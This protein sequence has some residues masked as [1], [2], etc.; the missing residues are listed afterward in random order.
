VVNRNDQER[1]V[2]IEHPVRNDFK[3]IDTDKP[4]ETA[5]DFYR[6]ELPVPAGQS[7]KLVVTEERV[8]NQS[9]VFSN[10]DDNNIRIFLQSPVASA[11]V[12]A[13]LE[14]A[15]KLRWEVSK[16][17]REIQEQERQL[18]TITDDQARLRANLR[19]MPPTAAAYKR[20]L[21]KFDAQEVEIEKLQADIKKLQAQEHQQKKALEDFLASLDLD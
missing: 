17:Q 6:F 10:L 15:M 21:E 7:G 16:T 1:L 4:A 9:L 20:Y 3:L 2:L 18:K 19:E 5:S 14:Q 13:A 11:R 8:I 12:K